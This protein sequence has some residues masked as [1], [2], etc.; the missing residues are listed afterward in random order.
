MSEYRESF[1]VRL[2]IVILAVSLL[3][4]LYQL[5]NVALLMFGAVLLAVLLRATARIIGQRLSIAPRYL[6]PPVLIAYI[7]L[8]AGA[9]IVF[10]RPIGDQVDELQQLL[11][12]ALERLRNLGES[13]GIRSLQY[14]GPENLT[15]SAGEIAQ[16]ATNVLQRGATV[17]FNT[18]FLIFA[19]LFMALQPELYR[20]GLVRLVGPRYRRRFGQTLDDCGNALERW[21][22]VQLI[23]MAIVGSVIGLG[24]WLLGVPLAP[25]LGLIAGLFEFVP[26]LGPI[27]ASIPAILVGLS[28][29]LE[30]GVIVLIFFIVVNQLEG[31]ILIPYLQAREVQL[32]P[33]I[34]ILSAIALGTLFGVLGLILAVP[35]GLTITILVKRL[36]IESLLE[37]GKEAN[38]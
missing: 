20:D 11:P 10:G 5:R 22:R 17:I 13:T 23:T 9:L 25:L 27:L 8:S 4:L 19:A 21:L 31:N 14:L 26:Y 36:W 28:E 1:S 12:D 2:L 18:I 15:S 38:P 37:D 3:F 33:L 7:L 34:T 32:P 24:L 29:S 6:V 35:L 16:Q 30:L